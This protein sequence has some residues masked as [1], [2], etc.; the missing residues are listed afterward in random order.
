MDQELNKIIEQKLGT[1]LLKMNEIAEKI[2]NEQRP[3]NK[4]FIQQLIE[5][6]RPL[7]AVYIRRKLLC[8]RAFA[9]EQ[10]QQNQQNIKW[11]I[12]VVQLSKQPSKQ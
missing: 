4:E 3:L 12:S 7:Y 10:Q 9:D 5:E 1:H 8:H 2:E 6:I 11:A